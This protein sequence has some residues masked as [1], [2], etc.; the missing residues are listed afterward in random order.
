MLSAEKK[1]DSGHLGAGGADRRPGGSAVLPAAVRD[2]SKHTPAVSSHRH[3]AAAQ[4]AASGSF[5]RGVVARQSRRRF[6]RQS[7]ISAAVTPATA[8]RTRITTRSVWR[9]SGRL[10]RDWAAPGRQRPR[11]RGRRFT[12]FSPASCGKPSR[13][14]WPRRRDQAEETPAIASREHLR[15]IHVGDV[16]RAGQH[17]VLRAGQLV[18]HHLHGGGVVGRPSRRSSRAPGSSPSASAAGSRDRRARPSSR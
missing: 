1:L 10:S 3:G 16:A 6:E 4:E 9:C 17:D 7:R 11:Q 5:G 14:R 15:L 18:L 13:A 2:R 12:D 8:S